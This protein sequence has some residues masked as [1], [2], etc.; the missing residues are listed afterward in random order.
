[1]FSGDQLQSSENK[2]GDEPVEITLEGGGRFNFFFFFC[3]SFFF[4][5]YLCPSVVIG[6]G[7]KI[8]SVF[9]LAETKAAA[10]KSVAV[11]P[12]ETFCSSCNK[13][14]TDGVK[15][16]SAEGILFCGDCFNCKKCNLSL[17]GV[18]LFC[19]DGNV[20]CE[21]HNP[22]VEMCGKCD[23]ALLS[24]KVIAALGKKFHTECFVCSECKAPFANDDTIFVADGLA[25]CADHAPSSE[26][27]GEEEEEEYSED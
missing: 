18:D 8:T 10:K 12:A 2:L 21:N 6:E 14:F 25:F 15:A 3:S 1:L 23:K 7:D 24:G 17:I 22:M 9:A 26:F 13:T 16:W 20:F 5:F 27:E 19:V 4:L 11:K